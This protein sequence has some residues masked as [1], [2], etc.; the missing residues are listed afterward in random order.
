M[1]RKICRK[2]PQVSLLLHSRLLCLFTVHAQDARLI[3]PR[4]RRRCHYYTSLTMT[5]A[6]KWFV[7][8][9]V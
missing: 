7:Q 2:K 8:R 3:K 1:T 4:E 9:E 5:A 6:T